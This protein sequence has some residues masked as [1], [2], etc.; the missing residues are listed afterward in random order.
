MGALIKTNNYTLLGVAM[1]VIPAVFS[2]GISVS[3]PAREACGMISGLAACRRSAVYCH[4]PARACARARHYGARDRR[5]VLQE[6]GRGMKKRSVYLWILAFV[7]VV[8]AAVY[9]RMTGPT[10]PARGGFRMGESDL[11]FRLPRSSDAPGDQE[12]R[13]KVPDT[14]ITGAM[15]W[16][17]FP[18]EDPWQR[19]ELRRQGD[20]LVGLIPHQPP[21]GKVMYRIQ[22]Q[23]GAAE[24]WVTAEPVILRFRGMVP[25]YIMIP[26]IIL[27]F[28][29]MWFS[30]RAGLEALSKGPRLFTLSLGTILTL[31]LGGIILGPIV[32]KLAFGSFWTGWPIGQDLTDNK[33][34]AAWLAWLWALWRIHKRPHATGYVVAASVIL[35]I[36][37]LIPHS[38]LGSEI[39]YGG[40]A[41]VSK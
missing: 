41:P 1:P 18:T 26:H 22:F 14:G 4:I 7:A 13:V 3:A 31:T 40:T 21:A 30:T 12:I 9:Q 33:T 15:E 24:A 25:E 5:K 11:R 2:A 19:H 32:Q 28:L 23:D 29:A 36:V 39:D 10:Y 20:D 38:L 35:F 34:L 8:F 17:R 27:M 6:H 16:K 37:Y